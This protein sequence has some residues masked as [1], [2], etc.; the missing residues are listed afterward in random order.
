MIATSEEV[1]EKVDH[2]EALFLG[3]K[4]THDYHI[5]TYYYLV[6]VLVIDCKKKT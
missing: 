4:K 5:I 1:R 6:N 2:D 3:L